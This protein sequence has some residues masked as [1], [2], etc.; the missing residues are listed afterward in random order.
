MTGGQN[1]RIVHLAHLA[2]LTLTAEEK[3]RLEHEF[4]DILSYVD[5]IERVRATLQP[6]TETITGVRHVM[7]EDAVA[8]SMF[9]RALLAQAPDVA[10]GCI[11]VPP[12]R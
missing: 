9:V 10:E 5:Q 4:R 11:R 7:R 3:Q 6:L 8:P 1:E 12:V 2:R